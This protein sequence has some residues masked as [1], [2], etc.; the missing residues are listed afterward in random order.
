MAPRVRARPV[1]RGP[2]AMMGGN[3]LPAGCFRADWLAFGDR[4]WPLLG[5]NGAPALEDFPGLRG[6]PGYPAFV[7][8]TW[9]LQPRPP[10]PPFQSRHVL[11][12][13]ILRKLPIGPRSPHSRPYDFHMA[14]SDP[15]NSHPEICAMR[16]PHIHVRMTASSRT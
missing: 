6:S 8:W 15:A 3:A 5:A 2:P 1:L 9:P 4:P 12:V 16:G 13:A 11:A 14:T 7:F 10:A